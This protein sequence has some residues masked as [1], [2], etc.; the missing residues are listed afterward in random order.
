M[1]LIFDIQH[2]G[3][4]SKPGDMGAAYDLDG[5]G[6]T[7]EDGEREVDLVRQYVAEAGSYA[8]SLGCQVLHIDAGEYSDR[9]RFAIAK[10]RANPTKR[11]AYLA[12]HMNA[13]GG[14]Y[15]LVRPDA[16]SSSGK[17]LATAVSR[18]L[19]LLPGIQFSRRD[20]LYGSA[21]L[22][23]KAGHPASEAAWWTR[24]YSCIDGIYSGPANLSAVL[25]EPAFIDS[26]EHRPLLTPAGLRSIGRALVD[27]AVA[28]S[29]Q[30]QGGI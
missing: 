6:V 4:P 5:D 25:V 7:G 30:T 17:L 9:H 1:L 12:C 28:W 2:T 29:A 8:L 16:R 21:A 13:G 14:R 3:R 10:A 23:A 18:S 20:P 24:G 15:A 22:A 27:G 19:S 11:A 26:K